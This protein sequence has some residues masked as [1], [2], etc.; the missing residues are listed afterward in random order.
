MAKDI[1]L[2]PKHNRF[3]HVI[4]L[5]SSLST[6]IFLLFLIWVLS[7]YVSL[8]LIQ[9]RVLMV[10]GFVYCLSRYL[11]HNAAYIEAETN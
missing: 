11:I 2:P 4:I 3:K 10:C 6:L 7:L 5:L 9:L 1:L 8:T